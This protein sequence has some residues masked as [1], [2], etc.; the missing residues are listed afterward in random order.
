MKITKRRGR[1]SK[2][3]VPSIV[4]WSILIVFLTCLVF[5]GFYFFRVFNN[6]DVFTPIYEEI[7][8]ADAFFKE[9]IKR[10]D[11]AVYSILYQNS[12]NEKDVLFQNIETRHHN[13]HIWSFSEVLIRCPNVQSVRSITKAVSE[14][15]DLG[16]QITVRGPTSSQGITTYDIF[17][18]ECQ[19]HKI[20]LQVNGRCF[21]KGNIRPQIAIIVDDLGYDLK[22]AFSFIKLDLPLSLSIFPFATYTQIISE[23]A[24]N[25]GREV[26]LHLPME[27]KQYPSIKPGPG[28]M[29]LSMG[30]KEIKQVLNQDLMEVRYACGVNNHMGSSFTEH[31]NKMLVVLRELKKRRLFYID[32]RTTTGT[33][34]FKT[35]RQVGVPSA[36]RNVFLDNEVDV[37]S[38]RIQMERLLSMARHKGRAI[39]IGHPYKNTLKVLQ[40]YESRLKVEFDV[41]PVSE[42]VG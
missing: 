28:A 20:L 6:A 23:K 26:M 1:G 13:G 29:F 7:Y 27:P 25:Q 39:G 4:L 41:V 22:I 38:I 30:R 18:D 5:F 17:V 11:H 31:R 21:R 3:G 10:V 14:L 8:T 35:A 9:D 37:K 32:S 40:E 12:I 33:V 42:L 24:N 2:R 16:S 19:T 15:S 34:G 36:E